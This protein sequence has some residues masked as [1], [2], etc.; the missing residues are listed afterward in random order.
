M[1]IHDL[2]S[3]KRQ[4]RDHMARVKTLPRD[5]QIVYRE[6]QKYVF[7][8]GSNAAS[9]GMDVLVG[10]ADLFA[11]GAGRGQGV[12]EVTGSDVAAFCDALLGEALPPSRADLKSGEAVNRALNAW[13][14]KGSAATGGQR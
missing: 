4:W 12:L 1:T 14:K 9:E 6:I 5:Y 11:Q 2:I 8:V 3:Q 10:I 13:L 7:K